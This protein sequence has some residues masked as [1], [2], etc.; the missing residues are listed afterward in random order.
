[1]KVRGT[2]S[3]SFQAHPG[4]IAVHGGFPSSLHFVQ[5]GWIYMVSLGGTKICT[6]QS[7]VCCFL[8]SNYLGGK[9]FLKSLFLFNAVINTAVGRIKGND[10]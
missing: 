8:T 1:M 4:H 5:T 2:M 10:I 3:E 7:Y 9:D 6:H